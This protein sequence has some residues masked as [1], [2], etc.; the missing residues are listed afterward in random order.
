MDEIMKALKVIQLELDD[1]KKAIRE[2]GEN[3]TQQVTQ[4]INKILEEKFF[5][6]EEKHEKLKEIVDNQEKRISFLEKQ[7][8]QRN[9]VF[10]GIE[11]LESSYDILGKNMLK[12]LEQHFSVKLTYSD[13][14]EVKRLGK[15]NDRP[16]PVV[17]SF[18]NLD[19]KIKI[20]KQK[21]ALQDTGYYMKEDY[22]KQVLEKRKQLQEQLKIEREKGNMAFLKYD[23]L[24]IPKQT[25]K[26]KLSPSP[27]KPTEDTPKEINTQTK[28]KNKPQSQHDPMAR[29]T[30]STSE[31]V[32]KPGMLNFLTN[33]NTAIDK[34]ISKNKA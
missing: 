13:L 12:W 33:K 19:M 18:L 8:R 16:R 20:F 14:Q 26:R 5:A 23:K 34:E 22:P 25:S 30:H 1:H 9:I 3:V 17:V 24:V 27:T 32:I 31:R 6:L 10:F 4:N 2:S 7:A 21:R 29:R 15:K 28:K 11:E